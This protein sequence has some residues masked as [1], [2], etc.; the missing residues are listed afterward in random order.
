MYQSMLFN[1][2]VAQQLIGPCST[3]ADCAVYSKL[4]PSYSYICVR[5]RC[6]LVLAAGNSC[7]ASFQCS[8]YQYLALGNATIP[9]DICSSSHCSLD[10][11][12]EGGPNP[13]TQG[14]TQQLER[15]C[16]G[17]AFDAPCADFDGVSNCRVGSS[18][19]PQSDSNLLQVC[20]KN[21]KGSNQWIGVIITLAGAAT[22]NMGLNLM[23][24]SFAQAI[25]E[26]YQKG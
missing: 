11:L 10:T 24:A 2:V 16:A 1:L 5:Q 23:K 13:Y 14:S 26:K 25:R 6:Q 19:Q 4:Y 8:Q 18:C 12:C 7:T 9:D 22:L 3:T 15:C 17:A 21:E 20:K